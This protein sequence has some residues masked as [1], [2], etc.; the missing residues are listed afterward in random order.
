[1]AIGVTDDAPDVGVT[2]RVPMNWDINLNVFG[3]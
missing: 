2:L 3:R 1:V